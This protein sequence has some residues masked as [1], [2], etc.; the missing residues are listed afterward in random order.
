F[1]HKETNWLKACTLPSGKIYTYKSNFFNRELISF[2]D[3]KEKNTFS[4]PVDFLG[5]SFY[6]LTCYHERVNYHIKDNHGRFPSSESLLGKHGLLTRPLVNE[7]VEEIWQ[8]MIGVFPHITRVKKEYKL[9]L[10]HDVDRPFRYAGVP[11]IRSLRHAVGEIYRNFNLKSIFSEAY[12]Y[13]SVIRGDLTKDPN[14]TFDYLMHQSEKRGIISNFYF[15]CGGNSNYD[16]TYMLSDKEIKFLLGEINY[17][18]HKI[19]LHGSYNTVKDLRQLECEYLNLVNTLNDMGVNR[20][21][22]GGRQ[23]Y[24][25]WSA[26]ITWKLWDQLG[27]TY[28]ASVG[29]ADHA[30]FRT[31]CCYSYPAFDLDNKAQLSIIVKPLIFMDCTV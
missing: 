24:L 21:K 3:I 4:F 31:G 5:T 8:T 27:L 1:D 23:H 20:E 14:N 18:G 26:S 11:L 12:K 30:G 22:I 10:S 13:F 2:W 28:D 15:L 25:R 29:Y 9:H 19:G 7:Y 16:A 6:L 17:R